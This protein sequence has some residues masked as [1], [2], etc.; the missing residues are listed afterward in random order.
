MLP[1][2]AP[3]RTTRKEKESEKTRGGELCQCDL[4]PPGP[5]GGLRCRHTTETIEGVDMNV[6]HSDH[7]ATVWETKR[8]NGG[9]SDRSL[10]GTARQKMQ[11]QKLWGSR[12]DLSPSAGQTSLLKCSSP[13][14][15]RRNLSKSRNVCLV[16]LHGPLRKSSANSE[17]ACVA[18]IVIELEVPSRLGPH[19]GWEVR[20]LTRNRFA[21]LLLLLLCAPHRAVRVE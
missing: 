9:G 11:E 7:L 4:H 13:F 12:I 14:Q 19:G 3:H 10:D 2:C 6:K 21:P 20:K 5:C 16:G 8:N 1:I 15:K 17:L 18:P